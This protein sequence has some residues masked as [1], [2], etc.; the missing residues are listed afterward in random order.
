MEFP[1][2]GAVVEVRTCRAHGHLSPLAGRGRRPKRSAGRRVRG[3]C[4]NTWRRVELSVRKLPLT[5]IADA[6]RPLPASGERWRARRVRGLQIGL[7]PT[8]LPA[9]SSTGRAL[10]PEHGALR[11]RLAHALQILA[12]AAVRTWADALVR[13]DSRNQNRLH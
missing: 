4:G 10:V 9:S 2:D 5:R 7:R 11:A 1:C 6:V 3:M 12:C 8:S 13:N